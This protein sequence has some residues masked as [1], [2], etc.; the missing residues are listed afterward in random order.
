MNA[1]EQHDDYF[2]QIRNAAHQQGLSC[3]QKVT[4]VFYILTYGAAT[5]ATDEYVRIGESTMLESLRRF[6]KAA[7]EVFGDEYLR[8]P[9]EKVIEQ[10]LALVNERGFPG[11][12]G[13]LDCMHWRWRNFHHRCKVNFPSIIIHQQ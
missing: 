10:L 8:L 9:N 13:S 11:M 3:F 7:I 4:V 6:V 2:E 5:D 1:M 12:L